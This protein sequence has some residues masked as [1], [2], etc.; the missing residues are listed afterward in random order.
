MERNGSLIDEIELLMMS[1][2][3]SSRLTNWLKRART[4]KSKEKTFDLPES[5]FSITIAQDKA[6]DN[7]RSAMF[8]SRCNRKPEPNMERALTKG[9]VKLV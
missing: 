3:T 7:L 5:I 8:K 1:G 4:S 2:D 9:D 6:E